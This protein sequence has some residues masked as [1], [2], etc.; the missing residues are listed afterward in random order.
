MSILVIAPSRG[1]PGQAGELWASMRETAELLDTR[2]L[3]AVDSDDPNVAAYLALR[4]TGEHRFGFDVDRLIVRVLQPDETGN[5]VMA[6]N[7]AV[8]PF[9]DQH[10]LMVGM[11]NDD[12]RFRSKGWDRRVYETL[13]RKPGI[14]YGN[15]LFQGDALATSPFISVGVVRALGWYCL[16]VCEHLF[17]D[18][19]WI[20]LGR[21]A[22]CL[23]YLPDVVVEHMHPLAG[24]GEWDEGYER[25]N[26]DRVTEHDRVAYERWRDGPGLRDDAA[27]IRL[28]LAGTR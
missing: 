23:T 8:A 6:M 5:M 28:A 11:V 12:Q 15:D 10:E 20:D 22:N 17:V 9:L 14:A 4:E 16:P 18:N 27:R 24:K 2:L 7:T 26:N 19:A 3:L 25:A 13:L 21:K 1:R